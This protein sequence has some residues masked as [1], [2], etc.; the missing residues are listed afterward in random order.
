MHHF[1]NIISPLLLQASLSN[2]IPFPTCHWHFVMRRHFFLLC[3]PYPMS[4]SISNFYSNLM[5]TAIGDVMPVV[6]VEVV[7]LECHYLSYKQTSEKAGLPHVV[8]VTDEYLIRRTGFGWILSSY[9]SCYLRNEM[10]HCQFLIR[11]WK[12]KMKDSCLCLVYEL[13]VE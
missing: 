13:R 12:G 5:R 2:S 8:L 10:S 11:S 4:Y 9:F 1:V 6:L 3:V 7:K